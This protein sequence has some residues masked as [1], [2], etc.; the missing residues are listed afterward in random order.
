M[1][2]V[3]LI[4]TKEKKNGIRSIAVQKDKAAKL[5]SRTTDLGVGGS[6]QR[7]TE[8][9]IPYISPTIKHLTTAIN[10]LPNYTAVLS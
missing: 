10:L 6:T 3:I 7:Y 1:S 9:Y 8:T 2:K 4:S 5:F